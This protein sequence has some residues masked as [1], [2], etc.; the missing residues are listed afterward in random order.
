MNHR[1]LF[2][3]LSLVTVGLLFNTLCPSDLSGLRPQGAALPRTSPAREQSESDLT[4]GV[5]EHYQSGEKKGYSVRVV[6]HKENGQ[7]KA[8][9]TDFNTEKELSE[10]ARAFPEAV[11]WTVCFDGRALGSLASKTPSKYSF[12]ADVGAQQITSKGNI[13]T[14]GK[15]SSLFSGW[16]GGQTYRPLVLNSRPYCADP[17]KWHPEKVEASDIAA[18]K[19]YLQKTLQVSASKWSKATIKVNKSY[20]SDVRSAK[21]VSLDIAGAEII[22]TEGEDDQDTA[23]WFY[24]ER[25]AVRRLG[26][27]MLLV[28]IGD[29]DQDGDEEAVFKIQRYDNDGYTLYYD[30]FRHNA[31]FSWHY[32]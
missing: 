25:G 12:Y 20:G 11:T 29:Y 6:L 9:P 8:F 18:I 32:H 16:P 28:D 27:N 10:A 4:L 22:P 31:E 26:S 15:P 5:L 30:G 13:P 1:H 2:F 19:N 7:W 21:L 24:V 23:A 14:V 3:L 17:R